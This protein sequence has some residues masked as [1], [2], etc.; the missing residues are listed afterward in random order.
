M[1]NL[2][3]ETLQV[4]RYTP[5]FL[6]LTAVTGFVSGLAPAGV[7]SARVEVVGDGRLGG[8]AMAVIQIG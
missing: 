7:F 2:I 5:P 6:V 1:S 3:K 8:M 4:N